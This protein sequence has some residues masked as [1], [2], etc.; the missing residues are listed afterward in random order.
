MI[1]YAAIVENSVVDGIG[2]RLTVFLQGCTR[3][4]EGCHN[5]DLQPLEGGKEVTE[6]H[7]AQKVLNKLTPLH[8][9]VTFSGGEPLLQSEA[10][11]KVILLLKKQKPE[12]DVWV[13]TGFTFEELQDM[14]VLKAIDVLVDG[15]FVLKEKDLSL[16]FRGSR[17]Q[18]IVDVQASLERGRVVEFERAPF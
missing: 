1:R 5:P 2:I 7:L 6:E 4:C 3:G 13:Y 17:N 10:L 18:R 14:P 9:G 11:K 16:A 8:R 15:P 12:L